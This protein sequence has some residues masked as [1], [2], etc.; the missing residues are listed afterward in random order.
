M[1]SFADRLTSAVREKRSP[2][3]VGLDPRLDQLPVSLRPPLEASAAE[4]ADAFCEFC[5]GV[6]DA[7]A[8]FTPIVK[9]Q[10]AFFE[11]LGPAGMVA[12]GAVIEEAHRA[13]LLVCVDGKRNDI[14]TTAQAYANGWL[15]EQSPWRGDALTVSPYLGDDSLEPFTKLAAERD[16]GVF[17]L[18]K[19]SNPGG[20]LW[21][22]LEAEGKTLY[23]RVGEYVETIAASTVGA[24]GYGVAGAVVGATYPQQLAE[25]RAAMP[26]T[27]FL[28]P[29]FGAQG[30]AAADVAAGFDAQGL[31]AVV[32]SSRGVIFAYE[33]NPQPD[34]RDAVREAARSACEQLRA[35]TSA[36]QL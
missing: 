1:P 34:W 8:D 15:G 35:A 11:E 7:V 10:V 32:N 21:Q 28:I 17:V 31:G 19:T 33:K 12:L 30:G 6:I 5:R 2:L 24:S 13:G 25:L 9:P 14:G 26:H 29:G 22:D 36:G 16:A 3:M 4:R 18:V 20:A 27:W 23:R